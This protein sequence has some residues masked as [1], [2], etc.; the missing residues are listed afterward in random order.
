MHRHAHA[1]RPPTVRATPLLLGLVLLSSL[2]GLLPSAS[3]TSPLPTT[4]G[5]Q[6]ITTVVSYQGGSADLLGDVTI[7]SGGSLTIS[8]G[9]IHAAAGPSG[10]HLLVQPGGTLVLQ[11]TLADRADPSQWWDLTVESGATLSIAQSTLRGAGEDNASDG[12]ML[13]AAGMSITDSL[14]EGNTA[15]VLTGGSLT[16]ER[17]TLS[18]HHHVGLLA[19]VGTLLELRDSTVEGTTMGSGL[20]LLGSTAT[21]EGCV[22]SDQQMGL[23]AVGTDLTISDTT[24]RDHP[25]GA[26]DV[27]GGT[28]SLQHSLLEDGSGEAGPTSV[29]ISVAAAPLWVNDTTVRGFPTALAIDGAVAPS[30]IATS[31]LEAPA[32]AGV[33]LDISGGPLRIEQTT[34]S[35]SVGVR[36]TDESL[37]GPARVRL[38]D[39]PAQSLFVSPGSK[40]TIERWWSLQVV[41]T[42]TSGLVVDPT[43]TV[44]EIA[45]G[46][47]QLIFGPAALSTLPDPLT[48][49]AEVHA[50]D[51]LQAE[52]PF[53]LDLV[54]EAGDRVTALTPLD[55]PVSVK[56]EVDDLDPTIAVVEPAA[57]S[58]IRAPAATL[59]GQVI[60]GTELTVDG[61][62]VILAPEAPGVAPPTRAFVATV[63]LSEGQN[64]VELVAT[65]EA[66][67][68][69]ALEWSL[70]R[71]LTAP[72]LVLDAPFRS[73]DHVVTNDPSVLLS[74]LTEPGATIEVG[75]VRTPAGDDGRFSLSVGLE[76]GPNEVLLTVTDPAGN[77]ATRTLVVTLDLFT[78]SLEWLEP[79][80]GYVTAEP[81]LSVRALAEE[82]AQVLLDGV[83]LESV[84]GNIAASVQLRVGA[85]TLTLEA[86]DAAGNHQLQQRVVV[87]D[88]TP[89][90]LT[91]TQPSEELLTTTRTVIVV[92]GQTEV[93]ATVRVEGMLA[94]RVGGYYNILVPL[95]E[96]SNTL[97]IEASDGRG[98][99]RS[100]TIVVERDT[101]PPL[102]EVVSPPMG[103]VT[104]TSRLPILVE[105]DGQTRSMTLQGRPLPI[106][107]GRAI[108]E[109]QLSAT[110][111]LLTFVATDVA[112]NERTISRTVILDAV[113]LLELADLPATT[114]LAELTLSGSAEPGARVWVDGTE[115]EVDARGGFHTILQLPNIGHASVRIQTVDGAGNEAVRT[116][117]LERVR[118]TPLRAT[119]PMPIGANAWL[120]LGLI[121]LGVLVGGGSTE[122]GRWHLLLWLVVPL[123][124]RVSR[125]RNQ[126][127]D[128]YV[129]GQIHGYIVAN[130][131]D[132]YNSIKAALKVNNGTLAH[133]LRVLEREGLIKSRASS[134]YKRFYPSEMRVPEPARGEELTEIQRILLRRICETPGIAQKDLSALVGVSAS[135]INYHITHLQEQELVRSQRHGMRVG[136]YPLPGGSE[137]IEELGALAPDDDPEHPTSH[138]DPKP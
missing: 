20:L 85:T 91:V 108:G 26:L 14:L 81:T 33:G 15:V 107:G 102:I 99:V 112:G 128:H 83:V 61:Q 41:A 30:T 48:V 47:A 28:L 92:A 104:R 6:T 53:T 21:I 75:S 93:D 89:P 74:G 117:T 138:D 57:G 19:N 130:P 46:S 31:T 114:A 73:D 100:K 44:L 70:V 86:I 59:R 2:V 68:T 65:D 122:R 38:Y 42:Q 56:M 45:D 54:T 25:L 132:H 131:G 133:H 123:Y 124:T 94:D 43:T 78:P 118:A 120:T 101:I 9:I 105:V 11:G 35:G 8:G 29:G 49:R 62:E 66:G 87:Y 7:A 10:A 97:T 125:Q 116:M 69:V 32:D 55:G 121:V 84:Q 113:A 135:T 90:S 3:A 109:L 88:P 34:I 1:P 95:S 36:A 82:G 18:A 96:G 39:S 40:A 80:D 98:L 60:D 16:I 76:V 27:R 5:P 37:T 50:A 13:A 4:L 12:L 106:S 115:V 127:L 23:S 119:T 24:L 134:I 103:L 71:D 129:R 110:Q 137:V 79:A 17:S 136:Y 63:P 111:T 52:G 126:V 22:L 67:N 51:G 58:V 77:A 64:T 72:D